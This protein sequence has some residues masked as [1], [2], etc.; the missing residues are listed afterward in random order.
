[1]K[2]QLLQI[3]LRKTLCRF[4]QHYSEYSSKLKKDDPESLN[5]FES[6]IFSGI[7]SDE[8][9][10]PSTYDGIDQFTKFIKSLKS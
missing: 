1:V 3:D 4:I 9:N 6:L 8:G 7:I 10:I 2:S 5:K